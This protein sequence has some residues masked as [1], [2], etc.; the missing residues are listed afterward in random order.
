VKLAHLKHLKKLDVK[1][2][3][4]IQITDLQLHLKT[5]KT[6]FEDLGIKLKEGYFQ[7]LIHD[8]DEN[9]DGIV[10]FEEFERTLRKCL[11]LMHRARTGNLI[12]P[13]FSDFCENVKQVITS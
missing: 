2:Q 1:K 10:T 13:D 11:E 7:N 3:G 5:M 8:M 6:V 9:N 4:I 12:I